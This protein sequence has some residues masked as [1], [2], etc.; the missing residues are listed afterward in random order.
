M[1]IP[2]SCGWL[3]FV[4]CLCLAWVA[5]LSSS[6]ASELA[7]FLKTLGFPGIKGTLFNMLSEKQ[8]AGMV[9]SHILIYQKYI[10]VHSYEDRNL[11]IS[12]E[13]LLI[14]PPHPCLSEAACWQNSDSELSAKV[15]V[16]SPAKEMCCQQWP[17]PLNMCHSVRV[18]DRVLM[19]TSQLVSQQ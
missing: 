16:V 19:T 3:V 13:V 8:S 7:E 15:L 14:L 18:E 12:P 4:V 6:F 2:W 11:K 10:R 9:P 1:Y 5:S 17:G